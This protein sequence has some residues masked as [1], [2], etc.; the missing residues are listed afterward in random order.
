MG[1]AGTL[2]AEGP[3][4]SGRPELCWLLSSSLRSF[5]GE[6]LARGVSRNAEHAATARQ[7]ENI[8]ITVAQPCGACFWHFWGQLGWASLSSMSSYLKSQKRDLSGCSD[9]SPQS[10]AKFEHTTSSSEQLRRSSTRLR[11]LAV[12]P[13]CWPAD[14]KEFGTSAGSQAEFTS[15]PSQTRRRA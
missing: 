13:A 7:T 2:L 3:L 4:R 10:S 9:H 14:L 1:S 8:R 15:T 6:V 5:L 12:C 11:L